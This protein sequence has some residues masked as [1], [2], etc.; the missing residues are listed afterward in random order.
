MNRY[1]IIISWSEEDQ[2][3]ITEALELPCCMHGKTLPAVC[4]SSSLFME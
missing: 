1:E 4:H 2:V 3:F